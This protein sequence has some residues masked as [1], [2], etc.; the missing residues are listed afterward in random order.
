MSVLAELLMLGPERRDTYV[1]ARMSL[2]DSAARYRPA[3]KIPTLDPV[4]AGLD[5]G[6]DPA[7]GRPHQIANDAIHVSN[8]PMK[9]TG[10]SPVTTGLNR[11][12][13]YVNSKGA[14]D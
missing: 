1:T 7:I 12:M 11:C 2:H 5:P 10:S 13:R 9:M 3:P 6:L 4:M 14:W 8:H